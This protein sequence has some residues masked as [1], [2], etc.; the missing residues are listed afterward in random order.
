MARPR[1][2]FHVAMLIVFSILWYLIRLGGLY[3]LRN[4]IYIILSEGSSYTTEKRGDVADYSSRRYW[5]WCWGRFDLWWSVIRSPITIWSSR[6]N[7]SQLWI[8]I[9]VDGWLSR[10]LNRIRV[11]STVWLGPGLRSWLGQYVWFGLCSWWRL[12]FRVMPDFCPGLGIFFRLR[13]NSGLAWLRQWD[14][15]FWVFD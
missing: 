1:Q 2:R 5:R 11:S 6:E 8:D 10:Q 15:I 3:L 13:L 7:N 4:H 9:W 12:R 14:L